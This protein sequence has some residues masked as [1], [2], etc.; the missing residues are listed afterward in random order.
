MQ[1]DTGKTGANHPTGLAIDKMHIVQLKGCAAALR[2]PGEA[3]ISGFANCSNGAHHP[4]GLRIDKMNTIELPIAVHRILVGPCA[5]GR[6]NHFNGK[7]LIIH[8]TFAVTDLHAGIV[9][10][11]R[12]QQRRHNQGCRRNVAGLGEIADRQEAGI[13]CNTERQRVTIHI[14]RRELNIF[15]L[16]SSDELIA[17]FCQ[18]R[19]SI[20]AAR[21]HHHFFGRWQSIVRGSFIAG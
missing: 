13:S 17:D 6:W 7:I 16:A 10:A 18:H 1:I 11:L 20:R 3:T 2:L 8:T 4:A 12:I 9:S 14:S 5:L 21:A 15:R 19:R